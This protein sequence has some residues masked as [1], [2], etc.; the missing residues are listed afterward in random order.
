MVDR[1]PDSRLERLWAGEFGDDYARRNDQVGRGRGPF[2]QELLDRVKP[3]ST[4][5]VGCNVGGNLRWIAP[6]VAQVAGIDVNEGALEALRE[7]L[8][9]V[10][11]RLAPARALP[12]PDSSFDLVFTMGVLIH[13][14]TEDLEAVLS[15]IV[16]CSRR[17]VLCGEYFDETEV[18]VPYHGERGA[19][20]RRDYGALYQQLFGDLRLID[21]GFLARGEDSTWDDVTWWLFE[22]PPG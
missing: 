16:R 22:L 5:E 6:E 18:E 10:D 3:E 17:Y 20:F 11:A 14:P 13:Q 9:G 7:R 4:L 1:P 15:E 2:W 19:L 8:P 12:F 21:R